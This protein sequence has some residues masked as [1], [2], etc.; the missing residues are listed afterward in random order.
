MR[1]AP[2]R[3]TCFTFSIFTARPV[4]FPQ[5]APRQFAFEGLLAI[6]GGSCRAGLAGVVGNRFGSSLE[7]QRR[8]AAL[9]SALFPRRIPVEQ[10]ASMVPGPSSLPAAARQLNRV[11]VG[12]RAF[13]R[14]HGGSWLLRR[15]GCQQQRT[16]AGGRTSRRTTPACRRYLGRT[17]SIAVSS[18]GR[19]RR[20]SFR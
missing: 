10:M 14:Q 17:P 12:G 15:Q 16:Q 2:P 9:A 7:H 19:A 20:R 11:A 5:T 6:N 4:G 8:E 18:S 13:D 1:L 3:R